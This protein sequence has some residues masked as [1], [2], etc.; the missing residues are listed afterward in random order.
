MLLWY[1][2]LSKSVCHLG[3]ARVFCVYRVQR[4][5]RSRTSKAGAANGDGDSIPEE[6]RGAPAIA[7]YTTRL[8][9]IR[10]RQP[11]YLADRARRQL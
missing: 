7:A 8:L 10:G 11:L 5:S 2:A 1:S 9:F 4:R 3:A 6:Y